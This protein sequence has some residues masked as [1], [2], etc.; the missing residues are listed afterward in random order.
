MRSLAGVSA[1]LVTSASGEVRVSRE[2]WATVVSGTRLFR[3]LDRGGYLVVKGLLHENPW[4]PAAEANRARFG[5]LTEPPPAS[6]SPVAASAQINGAMHGEDR[7]PI[8][9]RTSRW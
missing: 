2:S 6:W 9:A 7:S 1:Y 3:G 8:L 5:F 4:T